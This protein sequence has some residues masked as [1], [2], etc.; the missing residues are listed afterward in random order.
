MLIPNLR[1]N[2]AS[3]LCR[4]GGFGHLW[5]ID[6]ETPREEFT[7]TMAKRN[8]PRVLVLALRFWQ[9]SGEI[10]IE[11]LATGLTTPELSAVCELLQAVKIGAGAIEEWCIRWRSMPPAPLARIDEEAGA[12]RLPRE[13]ALQRRSR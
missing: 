8:R 10:S 4:L 12:F 5:D 11:D 2:V 9:G 3:T 13:H 7:S 1:S 6:M